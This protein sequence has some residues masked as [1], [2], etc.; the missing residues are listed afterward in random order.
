MAIVL[1]HS[2]CIVSAGGDS[3]SAGQ[4]LPFQ[5]DKSQNLSFSI[6]YSLKTIIFDKFIVYYHF[7]S[8][9][10]RFLW[11]FYRLQSN[12]YQISIELYQIFSF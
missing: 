2:F 11:N 7:L 6:V 9:S 3:M 1:L 12:F 5:F 4:D 10:I 8:F